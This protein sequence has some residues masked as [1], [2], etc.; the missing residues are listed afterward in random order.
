MRKETEDWWNGFSEKEKQEIKDKYH[1]YFKFE[2]VKDLSFSEK[3]TAF[4]LIERGQINVS[5]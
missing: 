4:V 1:K 2:I 5:F 3:R